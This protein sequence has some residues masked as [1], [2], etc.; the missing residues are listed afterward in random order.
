LVRKEGLTTSGKN[1]SRG[2]LRTTPWYAS[3]CNDPYCDA[4]LMVR[5]DW[6]LEHANNALEKT[7]EAFFVYVAEEQSND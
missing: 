6:I 7:L 4:V 1:K 2:G 3:R 5:E